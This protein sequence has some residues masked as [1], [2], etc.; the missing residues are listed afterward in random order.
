MSEKDIVRKGKYCGEIVQYHDGMAV[1]TWRLI[2]PE[3]EIE[4]GDID[5]GIVAFEGPVDPDKDEDDL[6]RIIELL[7]EMKERRD[8]REPHRKKKYECHWCGNE[9]K[10]E[11][12][13]IERYESEDDK[14][15]DEWHEKQFPRI[16]ICDQC[17]EEEELEFRED[18]EGYD[19]LINPHR[20]IDRDAG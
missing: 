9:W 11:G 15:R 7:Q 17:V 16:D 20:D 13:T 12:G 19:V 5:S 14:E 8:A 10:G 4:E 6:D 3:E 1:N 18:E 2:N